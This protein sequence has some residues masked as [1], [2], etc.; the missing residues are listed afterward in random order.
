MLQQRKDKGWA[1]L[2]T[3]THRI[4][5]GERNLEKLSEKN[6]LDLED[7]MIT[8]AILEKIENP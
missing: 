5:A 7:V 2:I 4:L 3:A 8:H 1:K 6:G